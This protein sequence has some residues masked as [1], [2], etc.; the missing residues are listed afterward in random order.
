VKVKDAMVKNVI[1]V[2]RSASLKQMINIFLQYRIDSLPVIDAKQTIVGFVT[3]DQV[4]EVLMPRYKEILRDYTYL[5]DFGRL[6]YVFEA[7]SHLLTEEKLILVD[8][9]VNPKFTVVKEQESLITAA[10]IMQANAIRRLPVVDNQNRLT[11]IISTIDIIL[12]L[13]KS[14]TR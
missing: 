1:T 4:V 3:I 13:F 9:L 10:A 5:E 2:P 8:D 14:K 6:E 7:Q 12:Y 11:G